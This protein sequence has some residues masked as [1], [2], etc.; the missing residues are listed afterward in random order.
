[1]RVLIYNLKK[2]ERFPDG[3]TMFDNTNI[4]VKQYL[5]ATEIH[6]FSTM[7][8]DVEAPKHREDLVNGHNS[9]DKQYLKQMTIRSI[10]S[11]NEETLG[12]DKKSHLTVVKNMIFP[13]L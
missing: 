11:G 12:E 6:L 2:I 10:M 1:M 4:Y 13:E 3:R 9:C 8:H 5:C 7:N